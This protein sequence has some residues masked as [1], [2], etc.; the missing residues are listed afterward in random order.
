MDARSGARAKR[1]GARSMR[2]GM[3]LCV[4]KAGKKAQVLDGIIERV[5][6]YVVDKETRKDGA[7]CLYP[8]S[9]VAKDLLST[10]EAYSYSPDLHCTPIIT[11]SLGI[12]KKVQEI[13]RLFTQGYCNRL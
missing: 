10:E 7:V 1:S 2:P 6:I 12:V 8:N 9:T 3:E 4:L 11:I 13:H 5:A